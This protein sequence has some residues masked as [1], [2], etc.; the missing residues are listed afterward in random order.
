MKIYAFAFVFIFPRIAE[1]AAFQ[2]STKYKTCNC[3]ETL[4]AAAALIDFYAQTS[5]N[6]IKERKHNCVLMQQSLI[7]AL[8][9]MV[10]WL[11]GRL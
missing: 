9:G 6:W 3:S 2:A 4:A 11:S 5:S 10:R 7:A 1:P 8:G